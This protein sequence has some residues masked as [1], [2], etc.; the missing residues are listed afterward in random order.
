[1]HILYQWRYADPPSREY[2]PLQHEQSAALFKRALQLLRERGYSNSADLLSDF[3]FEIVHPPGLPGKTSLRVIAS[4]EDTTRLDGV[5]SDVLREIVRAFGKVSCYIQLIF[6]ETSVSGHNSTVEDVRADTTAASEALQ[7]RNEGAAS[8]S[9]NHINIEISGTHA[10][11]NSLS[12]RNVPAL[13]VVTGVNG[14]GKSQLLEVL[15]SSC[16]AVGA[17]P[18][19][20]WA[21]FEGERYERGEVFFSAGK[22]EPLTSVVASEAR[23]REAIQGVQTLRRNDGHERYIARKLG[24]GIDE[25]REITP[26]QFQRVLTPGMLWTYA[27]EEFHSI[28]LLFLAHRFLEREALE[29]GE[30]PNVTKRRFGEPPWDLLSSVLKAAGLA[31]TFNIPQPLK[32]SRPF[33]NEQFDFQLRDREGNAVPM[34]Q[35][36]DGERVLMATSVWRYHA[37]LAGRHHR[38]FLLDEPDAHLHPSLTRRFLNILTKTFI[39]ERGARVI[40]TTHSPSTVALAPEESLFQMQRDS[41]RISRVSRADAIAI[42]TDGFVAVQDSTRTIFLE[43]KSDPLFYQGIWQRLIEQPTSGQPGRLKPYPNL[44]FVFGQ[45]KQTILALVPQLRSRGFGNFLG[46]IDRDVSN[47]PVD[48]V[49]IL[50]R[51]AIEN[52]IYDPLHIY[53]HLRKIGRAPSLPVDEA[54]LSDVPRSPAVLQA[55][56]NAVASRV[57]SAYPPSSAANEMARVPVRYESVG[58]TLNYPQWL[59]TRSKRQIKDQFHRVFLQL[60]FEELVQNY[61]DVGLIP[62]DIVALYRRLQGIEDL[63]N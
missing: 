28:S 55:I 30:D 27:P 31:F 61:L 41:P 57:E 21:A 42:L 11:I 13:A 1:M 18:T 48:G 37:D 7:A 49:F 47:Q 9:R 36:S 43:G 38:L 59:F 22:W 52:Y 24:V 34:D 58:A 62:E 4:R 32:P 8:R 23:I 3:S 6:V 39:Q 10:S 46:I 19:E 26:V 25:L 5:A 63:T 2:V 17:P 54:E 51:Y 12:W 56:I 16:H 53:F 20:A 35:L 14:A 29:A 60:Q 33:S 45:G 40:L 15:G 44:H 50:G